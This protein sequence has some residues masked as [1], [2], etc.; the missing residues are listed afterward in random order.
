MICQH[1]QIGSGLGYARVLVT[2]EDDDYETA[3]CERCESLL[4]SE[5]G[6]TDK[7]TSVAGWKL[8]CRQCYHDKLKNHTLVAE[9]Y[10]K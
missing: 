5:A 1:L 2:P 7:L 4:L 9:G 6:W 8:F 10:M 3:M